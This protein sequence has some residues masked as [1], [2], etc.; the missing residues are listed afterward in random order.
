[1][2][3]EARVGVF[4]V[5]VDIA[6]AERLRF[7]YLPASVERLLVI[8]ILLVLRATALILHLNLSL[9]YKHENQ[10]EI[11]LVCLQNVDPAYASIIKSLPYFWKR[12]LQE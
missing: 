5:A 3:N 9:Y 10:S 8:Q 1:M 2:R 7:V 6:T 11:M 4:R 12:G